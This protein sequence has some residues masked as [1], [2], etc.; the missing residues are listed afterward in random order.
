[1]MK[2]RGRKTYYIQPDD[3]GLVGMLGCVKDRKDG[4]MICLGEVL[5]RVLKQDVGKK[6]QKV[7]DFW[8]VESQEQFNERK[9]KYSQGKKEEILKG[10]IKSDSEVYR[11]AVKRTVKGR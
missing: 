9:E 3:V 1:M 7:G 6:M 10:F 11:E 8:Y 5:G 4:E 2:V